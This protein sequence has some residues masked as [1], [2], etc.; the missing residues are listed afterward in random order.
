MQCQGHW[1]SFYAKKHARIK[2]RGKRP[3]AGAAR[4]SLHL[5]YPGLF[6]KKMLL[7]TGVAA[8]ATP[9]EERQL[10]SVRV[11]IAAKAL[12]SHAADA[13]APSLADSGDDG[14]SKLGCDASAAAKGL[15][16]A[17]ACAGSP[18]A[19]SSATATSEVAR[20]AS[21]G[22]AAPPWGSPTWHPLFPLD[23]RGW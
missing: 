18:V 14:G 2:G 10:P 7:L 22:I 21:A 16:G 20:D 6:C 12:A 13:M 9:Q 8:Q 1:F 5:P 11:D 15:G 23:M 4:V 19:P 3:G 17:A